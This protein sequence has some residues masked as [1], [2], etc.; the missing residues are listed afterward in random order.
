MILVAGA[1][2]APGRLVVDAFLRK[3]HAVRVLVRGKRAASEF[4]ARG[5]EI[6]RGDVRDAEKVA[7]ACEGAA[8][9]VS[10]IG[11]HFAATREGLWA[12]DAEGN[13]AL[14]TAARG[15]GV[16][17]FVLLSALFAEREL[18]PVLLTAKRHAEAALVASKLAY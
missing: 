12:V 10:L 8:T 18:G 2:S 17:R 6:A 13:A 4:A 9:V 16:K 15:A 1:T 5:V 7:A 3:G 14:V 11:R